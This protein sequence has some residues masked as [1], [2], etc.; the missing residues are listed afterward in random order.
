MPCDA[1]HERETNRPGRY[2]TDECRKSIIRDF[3]LYRV[4]IDIENFMK[5]VLHVPD[6]WRAQ[7]GPAIKKIKADNCFRSHHQRY[8]GEVERDSPDAREHAFRGPLMD[9]GYAILDVTSEFPLKTVGPQT[10]Q[11][12]SPSQTSPGATHEK[13]PSHLQSSESTLVDE[14]CAPGLETDGGFVNTTDVM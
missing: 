5:H 14:S 7:W 10:A 8:H 6:D 9:L 11:R 1:T 13:P 4:R 2:D 12:T 3:Q